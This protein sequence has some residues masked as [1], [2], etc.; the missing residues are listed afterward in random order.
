M[1]HLTNKYKVRFFYEKSNTRHWDLITTRHKAKKGLTTPYWV[2]TM[3]YSGSFCYFHNLW[4][5]LGHILPRYQ[6]TCILEGTFAWWKVGDCHFH[7]GHNY[8]HTW[9]YEDDIFGVSFTDICIH[10]PSKA[11]TFN[12]VSYRYSQVLLGISELFGN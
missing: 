2:L 12:A 1:G 10:L 7:Q 6:Y 5:K 4:T 8:I 3:V 11:N 9:L